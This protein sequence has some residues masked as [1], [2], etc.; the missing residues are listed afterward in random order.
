MTDEAGETANESESQMHSET[1]VRRRAT[2]LNWIARLTGGE[3]SDTILGSRTLRS[4]ADRHAPGAE[5]PAAPPEPLTISISES[6]TQEP[7]PP[8][9]VAAKEFA[10][11]EIFDDIENHYRDGPKWWD[12]ICLPLDSTLPTAQ[13]RNSEAIQSFIETSK[14]R[15]KLDSKPLP[16]LKR[17]EELF[18]MNAKYGNCAETSAYS[19][20]VL[21]KQF[22]EDNLFIIRLKPPGDHSLIVIGE[23]PPEV[24][25]L[26]WKTVSRST[27]CQVF[28]V[29]LGICCHISKYPDEIQKQL[30]KFAAA[31]EY[32]L[33][34]RDDEERNVLMPGN[35]QDVEDR[36]CSYHVASDPAYVSDLMTS[37]T[38]AVPVGGLKPPAGW[39]FP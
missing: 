33:V 13:R 29:W 23:E 30:D 27:F 10:V 22:P 35:G 6:P 5:A 20:Y 36:K 16:T 2:V 7:E 25:I 8:E 1:S 19:A 17:G 28:D 24:S 9:S 31:G 26:E 4:Y 11:K 14:F 3:P 34:A 18:R 39:K 32:I 12:R 37:P 15:K 21:N 38:E